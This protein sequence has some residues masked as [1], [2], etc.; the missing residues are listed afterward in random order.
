MDIEYTCI[1]CVDKNQSCV[2]YVHGF[3]VEHNKRL[4]PMARVH[5]WDA[6][7]N[8]DA[9]ISIHPS[10]EGA[11][12]RENLHYT[13]RSGIK[14]RLPVTE[15]CLSTIRPPLASLCTIRRITKHTLSHIRRPN[16]VES[17]FD[18]SVQEHPK[19]LFGMWHSSYDLTAKRLDIRHVDMAQSALSTHHGDMTRKRP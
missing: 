17:R 11:N 14:M 5:F 9:C 3:P 19:S 8:A 6:S 13:W 16:S 15:H 7:L 4:S 1:F 12:C 2:P 18:F 10:A